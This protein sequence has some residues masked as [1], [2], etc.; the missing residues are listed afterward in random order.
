[1]S[2]ETKIDFP[3]CD[4]KFCTAPANKPH[5]HREWKGGTGNHEVFDLVVIRKHPKPQKPCDEAIQLLDSLVKYPNYNIQ[6]YIRLRQL[7]LDYIKD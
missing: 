3:E 7:I 5:T 1:M 4:Y 6:Y 2:N